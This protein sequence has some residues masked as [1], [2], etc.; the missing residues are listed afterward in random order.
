MTSI[1]FI[2]P[3]RLP[4]TE[5]FNLA[6]HLSRKNF[7]GV[8]LQPKEILLS[9][10]SSTKETVNDFEIINFPCFF[11]P[12]INYT[13]PLLITQLEIISKI[14]IQKKID[15]I[16]IADYFYPTSL[17]PIY[18][19]RRY[20]IPIILTVNAIPGYS[21]FYG[22]DIIDSLAKIYT[23]TIGKK[24]MNFYDIIIPIYKALSN[25]VVRFGVDIEKVYTIHNGVDFNKFNKEQNTR[26][27]KQ[28]LSIKEDE[29]V[30]LFVGRL[31]QV[32]RVDIL[33]KV[34]IMLLREGFKIKTIIVG[35]GPMKKFYENLSI[36]FKNNIIFT[37]Y[38]QK[39]ELPKFY[40]LADVLVLPSLSEGLPNVIL[41]AAA[42]GTTS[43]ATSTGGISD[44]IRHEE[45]GFL[46]K[47]ENINSFYHYIK[48]LIQDDE[49][50]KI[51]GKKI[52]IYVN[53]NFDWSKIIKKY[54]EL[55]TKLSCR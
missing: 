7:N 53:R 47:D 37:G 24:I 49:L 11:I 52:K 8:I 48:M 40:Q 13:I 6:R 15:I 2:N 21:W 41:E 34:T 45:N 50:L 10:S 9:K 36:P 51:M 22:N 23:Y 30:L 27:L 44:I 17:L 18:I 5:V 46:V 43:V 16:Q 55:Y 42:A 12:V 32:K 33:I 14:V 1:C 28:R 31:V 39:E 29:K 26:E 38:I 4:K 19:N 3:T 25:E 35:D 20:K 54:I